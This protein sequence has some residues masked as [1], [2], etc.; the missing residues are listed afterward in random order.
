MPLFVRLVTQCICDI[1]IVM[2]GGKSA[3]RPKRTLEGNGGYVCYVPFLDI[4]VLFANYIKPVIRIY[5][6]Y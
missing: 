4:R 6:P 5:R 1:Y 3:S 2:L